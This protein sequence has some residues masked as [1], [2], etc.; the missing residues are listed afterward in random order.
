V[1]K[2]GLYGQGLGRLGQVRANHKSSHKFWQGLGRGQ[3]DTRRLGGNSCY[4]VVIKMGVFQ[5]DL[6]PVGDY[7]Y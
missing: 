4:Q 5:F 6:L 2:S 7:C 3:A 1:S